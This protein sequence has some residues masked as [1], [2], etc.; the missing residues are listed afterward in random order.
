MAREV[1]NL[2]EFL[3]GLHPAFDDCPAPCARTIDDERP[4]DL[5]DFCGECEV[6]R[7]LDFFERSARRELGRRFREGECE[8]SFASLWGD[9]Q[10]VMKLARSARRGQYP[11]GVTA[12][13]ARCIDLVRREEL[14]PER[15]R[16]WERRQQ[17]GSNAN[18]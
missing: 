13:E 10:R 6:R 15:V 9:V 4:A 14:R 8:W 1:V 11:R 16:A 2:Q 12:L 17:A 5:P 3:R 7:Q 18:G